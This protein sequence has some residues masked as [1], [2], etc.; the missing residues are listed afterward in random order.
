MRKVA[1]RGGKYAKVEVPSRTPTPL[2]PPILYTTLQTRPH[3]L[4]GI[5]DW[6]P[7]RDAYNF[8]ISTRHLHGLIASLAHDAAYGTRDRN[9]PIPDPYFSRAISRYAHGDCSET[10]RAGKPGTRVCRATLHRPTVRLRECEGLPEFCPPKPYPGPYPIGSH[11]LHNP[12]LI[13]EYDNMI[14]KEGFQEEDEGTIDINHMGVC[15]ECTDQEL[16]RIHGMLFILG[17]RFDGTNI[18]TSA[19][20]SESAEWAGQGLEQAST[21]YRLRLEHIYR[22]ESDLTGAHVYFD[23][24]QP[25]HP[26]VHPR[27]RCGRPNT[28]AYRWGSV[29]MCTVCK[30]IMLKE[31]LLENP[32]PRFKAEIER[33][34]TSKDPVRTTIVYE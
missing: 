33:A 21:A 14:N 16:R 22:D 18:N 9:D 13:C 15:K 2:R 31:N 6:L 28:N 19:V 24:T 29:Y 30:T 20:A 32:T 11:H 17:Q 27:C 34:L 3:I 8:G 1:R 26:E 25:P 7:Q 10:K 23:Y 12:G 5:L 4:E